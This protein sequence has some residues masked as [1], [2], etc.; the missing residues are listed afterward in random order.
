MNGDRSHGFQT[1]SAH[2]SGKHYLENIYNA[3]LSPSLASMLY[4]IVISLN[5][6]QE[7]GFKIR[8]KAS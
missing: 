1:P 4:G 7:V 8:G 3:I 6:W 2:S 5:T